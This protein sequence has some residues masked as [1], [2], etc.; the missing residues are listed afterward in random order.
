MIAYDRFGAGP[1]LLLIHGVGHDRS[2]WWPIYDRLRP[3]RDVIAIDL[4][5]HGRTPALPAG[6]PYTVAA[7]VAAVERFIDAVPL[8]RPRVA[9]N[10]LGGA[11]ALELAAKGVAGSAVALAPIGFWNGPEIAYVMASLRASR[12][13]ARLLGPLLP[14]L[15][16]TAAGRA[17]LLAQFYGRPGLVSAADAYAAV[18]A[19]RRAPAL[20]RTLPYT[21]WYR[22]GATL[23]AP[24]DVTVAWGTHDRLLI[25]RQAARA[26]T[27]LPAARHVR[28]LGPAAGQAGRR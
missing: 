1:A 27:A 21:R 14:A 11:I 4:P 19:F 23:D 9:G 2:A 8:S 17:V 13:A 5:G 16:S 10:S 3:Y 28:L 25:G 24:A 26:R 20:M 6:T 22:F 15:L 12:A 18:T 7:Y